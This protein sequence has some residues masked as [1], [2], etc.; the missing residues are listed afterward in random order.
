MV[1]PE[2]S[3]GEFVS[4][5]LEMAPDANSQEIAEA[6]AERTAPE[7]A[8][9]AQFKQAVRKIKRELEYYR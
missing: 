5:Y 3:L 7:D 8:T 9:D 2:L 1:L 6:F 4:D